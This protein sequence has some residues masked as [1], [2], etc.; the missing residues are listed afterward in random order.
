MSSSSNV[1]GLE[2]APIGWIEY[3]WAVVTLNTAVCPPSNVHRQMLIVLG[4]QVLWGTGWDIMRML[5]A[6][7]VPLLQVYRYVLWSNCNIYCHLKL[8]FTKKDIYM[9]Q[10]LRYFF[11]SNHFLILQHLIFN[12][13]KSP[14]I[15]LLN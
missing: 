5:L 2:D 8:K 12:Y 1:A 3:Q 7:L 11:I 14:L 6:L 10:L 13:N 9:N 4:V 15:H